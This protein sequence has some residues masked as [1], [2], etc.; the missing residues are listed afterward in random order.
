MSRD[1]SVDLQWAGDLRKFRLDIANLIA[2]QDKRDAG[3]QELLNRFRGSTWRV[4]DLQ[5][6]IRL[7]LVGGGEDAKIAARL[8]GEQV[9]AG[10]LHENV[11]VAMAI[12]IHAIQAPEVDPVGKQE[13][14]TEQPGA[15]NSQPL[16][17]TEP[18][19]S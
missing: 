18:A 13:A 10:N 15:T 11:L 19:Q 6:T 12:L 14:A 16:P 5:E 4:Q 17:S 3:P 7:G 9:T 8:I 2:L 1:G